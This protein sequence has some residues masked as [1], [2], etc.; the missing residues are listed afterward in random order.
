MLLPFA[1]HFLIKTFSSRAR[2]VPRSTEETDWEAIRGVNVLAFC[3]GDTHTN[4]PDT[5]SRHTHMNCNNVTM[6]FC[7][8]F[9]VIAGAW[10]CFIP[11]EAFYLKKLTEQTK[12]RDFGKDYSRRRW[13]TVILSTLCFTF[14]LCTSHFISPHLL[15]FMFHTSFWISPLSLDCPLFS[16][17]L[18]YLAVH[19]HM[20]R[21]RLLCSKN[22]SL[23]S[24]PVL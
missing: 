23:Y 7:D 2:F 17:L 9:L 3:L 8:V 1:S 20:L 14:S 11:Q 15:S 24:N 16:R 19:T 21:H 13:E 12:E 18:L 22:S 5:C 10:P 4:H 6:M